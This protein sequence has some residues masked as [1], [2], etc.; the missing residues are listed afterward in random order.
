MGGGKHSSPTCKS[1]RAAS[2]RSIKVREEQ[3][4][5]RALATGSKVRDHTARGRATSSGGAQALTSG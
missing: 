2:G 5:A 1:H 4:Q 3:Q